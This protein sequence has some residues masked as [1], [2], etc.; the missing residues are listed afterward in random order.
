MPNLCIFG[1]CLLAKIL[2]IKLLVYSRKAILE[3]PEYATARNLANR[4]N[5]LLKKQGIFPRGVDI[6]EIHPVKFGGSP[7]DIANKIALPRPTHTHY[8]NWWNRLQKDITKIR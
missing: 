5:E 4:T 6:H 1:V 3:N 8:T 7:T 2:I